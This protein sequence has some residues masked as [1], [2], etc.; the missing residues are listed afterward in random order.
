M[1]EIILTWSGFI[2]IRY[3]FVNIH[4]W[5]GFIGVRYLCENLDTW[6]G[7]IGVQYVSGILHSWGGLIVA[8]DIYEETRLDTWGGFQ[9]LGSICVWTHSFMRGFNRVRYDNVYCNLDAWSGFIVV[10]Y[11]YGNVI[12]EVGLMGS[13]IC[14]KSFIPEVGLLMFDISL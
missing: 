12:L 4:K 8:C 11:A 1:F 6:G 13:D 3:V 9:W 7:F 10:R 5:G 14:L 2:S